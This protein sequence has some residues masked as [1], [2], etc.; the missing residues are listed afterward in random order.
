[1]TILLTY[2]PNLQKTQN[3]SILHQNLSLYDCLIISVVV[4]QDIVLSY[5]YACMS[6]DL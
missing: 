5:F 6:E 2:L 3:L 1:M 4:K